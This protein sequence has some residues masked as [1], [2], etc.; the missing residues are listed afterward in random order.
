MRAPGLHKSKPVVRVLP[1][2]PNRTNATGAISQCRFIG[3]DSFAST[4]RKKIV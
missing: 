3:F 1:P 2:Q 4:Q